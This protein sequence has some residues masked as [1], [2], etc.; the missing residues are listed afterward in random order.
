[1][2]LTHRFSLPA[3]VGEAWN[4]FNN[5]EQLAPCFPGATIT[6]VEGNEFTGQLRIKLGP[7]T[8][9]YDGSGRYLE[10]NEAERRMVIEARANEKRRNGTA[11]VTVSASFTGSGEQTDVE[12]HTALVINGK[13]AHFGN[14]VIADVSEKLLD[15]FVSCI[16][17]QFASGLGA[18]YE[19]SGAV[20]AETAAGFDEADNER[21]IELEP[22]PA[23]SEEADASAVADIPPS[24]SEAGPAAAAG[25]A[26]FA[27]PVSEPPR[28]AAAPQ[29]DTAEGALNVIGTVVP[30]LLKRFAPALAILGLLLFVVIKIIRRRS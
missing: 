26:D 25:V 28:D 6:D 16:S 7:S 17:G 8:L 22:V 24:A 14:E 9:V 20:T 29:G 5:V 2:D 12:V 15:Q 10:R 21:T 1:M 19:V 3:G 13:P 11:N 27:R 30:V 18:A 23:V 4:A